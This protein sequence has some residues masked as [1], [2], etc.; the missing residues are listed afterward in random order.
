M[1]V[2]IMQI[3]PSTVMNLSLRYN[4]TQTQLNNYSKFNVNYLNILLFALTVKHIPKVNEFKKKQ[5]DYLFKN[6]EKC[7]RNKRRQHRPKI[8]SMKQ[9]SKELMFVNI[10]ASFYPCFSSLKFAGI[11]SLTRVSQTL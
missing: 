6:N 11:T 2:I 7:Y 9:N 8:T 1:V 5:Y 3:P 10:M 4:V